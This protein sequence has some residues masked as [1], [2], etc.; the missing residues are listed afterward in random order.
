MQTLSMNHTND[1]HINVLRL[2]L[3][4]MSDICASRAARC[5]SSS[6]VSSYSKRKLPLLGGA[7]E[8][9]VGP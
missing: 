4:R 6:F 5:S 8:S 1:Q 9:A 2:E 3:F 7:L